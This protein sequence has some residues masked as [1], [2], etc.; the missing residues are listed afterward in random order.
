MQRNILRIKNIRQ[1]IQ[2]EIEILG[3]KYKP[4][5]QE[6]LT[7]EDKQNAL[8]VNLEIVLDGKIYYKN[9][10]TAYTFNIFAFCDNFLHDGNLSLSLGLS[11]A[12]DTICSLY[13]KKTNSSHICDFL[14]KLSNGYKEDN[15][16]IETTLSFASEYYTNDYI[17]FMFNILKEFP[18]RAYKPV[19]SFGYDDLIAE[20]KNRKQ[21]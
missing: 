14:L 17:L 4:D 5:T 12:L 6:Y 21:A 2:V 3:Y 19:S 20:F 10:I 13:L 15:E 18:N 9:Y 16:Y 7:D 8:E 11:P 1:N